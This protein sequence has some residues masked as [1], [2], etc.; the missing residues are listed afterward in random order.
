MNKERFMR[1]MTFVHCVHLFFFF[2]HLFFKD[3]F[4]QSE[5]FDGCERPTAVE[6]HC[7]LQQAAH[8]HVEGTGPRRKRTFHYNLW[9]F[10]WNFTCSCVLSKQ[11]QQIKASLPLSSKLNSGYKNSKIY[12]LDFN[13]MD[14]PSIYHMWWKVTRWRKTAVNSSYCSGNCHL[15]L[16]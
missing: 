6:T 10:L 11:W 1:G 7:P 9:F 14:L 3:K 16:F 5:P 8:R 13:W 2:F 12:Y 15:T 4:Q